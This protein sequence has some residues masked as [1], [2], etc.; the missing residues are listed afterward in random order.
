MVADI[1]N[2]FSYGEKLAAGGQPTVDQIK[3]LK[4]DGVETIVSISPASTP[5]YLQEE[6]LLTEQLELEYIHYPI[7]CS[8]LKPDHYKIFRNILK[9]L[10]NKKVFIHCG[11]NIKT[12]NLI[13]MYMVLEHGVP[14]EESLLELKKIQLPEDKWFNYFKE[15]GMQGIS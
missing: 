3:S 11:G 4:D 7:D 10:E 13:H 6:A 12:S 5:N 2:Y 15:M 14:E 8:N 9:A 1:L